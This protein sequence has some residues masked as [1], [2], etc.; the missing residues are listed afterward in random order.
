MV[1]DENCPVP[2]IP[3]ATAEKM[4]AGKLKT[5]VPKNSR[6][7]I[8]PYCRADLD[9]GKFSSAFHGWR[10]VKSVSQSVSRKIDCS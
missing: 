7:G 6:P 3:K 2:G 1:A 9:A 10:P 8:Y 5:E 4:G